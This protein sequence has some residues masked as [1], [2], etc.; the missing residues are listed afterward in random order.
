MTSLAEWVATGRA[1]GGAVCFVRSLPRWPEQAAGWQDTRGSPSFEETNCDWCWESAG[2]GG[3]RA[4][5]P[6][7]LPAGTRN[8]PVNPSAQLEQDKGNNAARGIAAR[9]K[10]KRKHI[11]LAGK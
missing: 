8:S 1:E 9:L 7:S 6:F 3:D 11:S 5:F 4:V 2:F 10:G